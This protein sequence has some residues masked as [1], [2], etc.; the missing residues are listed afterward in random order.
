MSFL[1]FSKAGINDK[2]YGENPIFTIVMS[3]EDFR[4]DV[5]WSTTE[6]TGFLSGK[7]TLFAHA[8]IGQLDVTIRIEENVVELQVT[9]DYPFLV[10]VV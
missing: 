1:F 9:I 2:E 3:T 7:E 10:Q 4:S 6:S 8:V 5:V